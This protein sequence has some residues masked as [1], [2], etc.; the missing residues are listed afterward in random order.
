MNMLN[1][2][3]M[4]MTMNMIMNMIINKIMAMDTNT[5]MNVTMTVIMNMTLTKPVLLKFAKVSMLAEANV[6]LQQHLL[7]I[8]EKSVVRKMFYSSCSKDHHVFACTPPTDSGY[9][10]D[11]R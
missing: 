10:I 3:N 9:K 2:M 1:M 5:T 4:N 11:I 8:D 6:I 7:E